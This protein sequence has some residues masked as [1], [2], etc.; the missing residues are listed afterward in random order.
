MIGGNVLRKMKEVFTNTDRK[1][2]ILLVMVCA[3]V[4]V[5]VGYQDV[6]AVSELVGYEPAIRVQLKDGAS[7]EKS[8][9]IKR[10]TVSQALNDMEV[11]LGEEDTCNLALD[12]EV[13]EGSVLEVTRVTYEEVKENENIPYKTEYVNA[14]GGQVFG[15][16]VITEG[17]NGQK[18]N[19]YRVKKVNGQEDSRELLNSTVVK[20]PVTKQV[21]R[22]NVAPQAT[23]SGVLTRYGA[24]CNG[25]SGRT[26][27]G[28]VVT[29]NG[30]KNSGK[31]T[32]SYNG[33]EYYVLAADRSIPFGTIIEVSNHNFSIPDPFYGIV[34]DRG[35]AIKGGHLDV[36]CGGERNSFFTGGTSRN[37]QYKIISVGNGRTGIY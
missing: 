20:E 28:L 1:F 18:E 24:D 27:A 32:L 37:T 15:N 10:G 6:G 23:F 31:V 7:E 5:L 9:L 4:M 22:A 21:A 26:A 35:G 8:Y 29:A 16:K 30:V 36:F 14:E 13:V 2:K 11:V 19:T 34:L 17:V 12:S 3:Y 33:G 25:C